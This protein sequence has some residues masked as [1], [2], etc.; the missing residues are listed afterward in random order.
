MAGGQKKG[1]WQ[2]RCS[3]R[4][5]PQSIYVDAGIMDDQDRTDAAKHRR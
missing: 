2:Q 3:N 4:M 5:W 1:H